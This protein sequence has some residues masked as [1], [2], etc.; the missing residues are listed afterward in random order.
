MGEAFIPPRSGAQHSRSFLG[1]ENPTLG[2]LLPPGEILPFQTTNLL[3]RSRFIHAL[4]WR[5]LM[6]TCGV[7]RRQWM[8]EKGTGLT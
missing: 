8:T 2:D 3:W 5:S 4:L 6:G 7:T 1:K